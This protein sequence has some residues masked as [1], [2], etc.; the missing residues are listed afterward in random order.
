MLDFGEMLCSPVCRPLCPLMVLALH[1]CAA[2]ASCLSCALL[3]LCP[4]FPCCLLPACFS[5]VLKD[6][7]IPCPPTVSECHCI[8]EGIPRA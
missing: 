8:T 7:V 3:I 2:L 6:Q 4:P 1:S 5:L